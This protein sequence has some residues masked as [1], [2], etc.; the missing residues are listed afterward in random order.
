[1]EG[2]KLKHV[3]SLQASCFLVLMQEQR[4]EYDEVVWDSLRFYYWLSDTFRDAYGSK[5]EAFKTGL[6]LEYLRAMPSQNNFW[7][8]HGDMDLSLF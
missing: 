2:R 5:F 3:I 8:T 1:M 7:G 6:F 4:G